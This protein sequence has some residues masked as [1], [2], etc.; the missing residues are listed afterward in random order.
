MEERYLVTLLADDGDHPQRLFLGTDEALAWAR[1]V[2]E[3]F[4]VK[5]TRFVD[6]QAV[7]VVFQREAQGSRVRPST[8]SQDNLPKVLS[9]RIT[10]AW[11]GDG[12][13]PGGV[14]IEWQTKENGFSRMVLLWEA[15]R[16]RVRNFSLPSLPFC[17]RVLAK[18]SEII[19][20]DLD[21][22]YLKN[23]ESEERAEDE[24]A[25]DEAAVDNALPAKPTK[26]RRQKVGDAAG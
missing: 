5:V 8:G 2:D 25:A 14:T 15:G 21:P 9:S 7:S 26:A 12:I 6:G 13:S 16:L 4:G 23:Y 1:T 24:E 3:W 19:T 20:L 10:D 17:R 11:E 18:L 22:D